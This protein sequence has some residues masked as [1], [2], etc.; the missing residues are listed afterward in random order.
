MSVGHSKAF[1]RQ[2]DRHDVCDVHLSTQLGYT[3]D[4]SRQMRE[5]RPARAADGFGQQGGVG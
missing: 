4:T 3:G 2:E 1:V 5:I